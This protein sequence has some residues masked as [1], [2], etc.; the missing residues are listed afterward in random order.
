MNRILLWLRKIIAL[1]LC[2]PAL[3]LPSRLR[4]L[5]IDLLGWIV[6]L[7]Y[8]TFKLLV[9][10]ILKQLEKAEPGPKSG[11]DEPDSRKNE[12]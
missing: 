11:V 6:Q 1:C 5:Y 10:F 2:I 9:G 4:V 3:L 7:Y 12:N 8:Y